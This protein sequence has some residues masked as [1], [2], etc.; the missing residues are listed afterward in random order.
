MTKPDVTKQL[1]HLQEYEEQTPFNSLPAVLIYAQTD[2][3]VTTVIKRVTAVKTLCR[4]IMKM[5]GVS[6]SLVI[7]SHTFAAKQTA[8][9]DTT[10]KK[11]FLLRLKLHKS[12]TQETSRM[13][14]AYRH[15]IVCQN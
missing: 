15:C 2:F 4:V 12:T 9:S 5:A 13:W 14:S 3:M 6:A 8:H 11:A 10:T 1:E 7:Q